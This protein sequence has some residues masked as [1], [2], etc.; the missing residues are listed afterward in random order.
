MLYAFI[1]HYQPHNRVIQKID[2]KQHLGIDE[3]S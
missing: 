3:K 2:N 1:K